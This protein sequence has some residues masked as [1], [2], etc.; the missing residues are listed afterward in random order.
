MREF[1]WSATEKKAARAAFD[2]SL[3]RELKAVRQE[4]WQADGSIK[5]RSSGL[6]YTT[7]I[8]VRRPSNRDRFSGTVLVDVGNRAQTFDTYAVPRPFPASVAV[9]P[10]VS[11]GL[12]ASSAGPLSYHNVHF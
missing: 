11:S 9:C 10:L 6:P 3:A 12:F 4:A 2:I 1:T 7:R 5:V 8:L